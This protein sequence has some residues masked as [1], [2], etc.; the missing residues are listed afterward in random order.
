[1]QLVERMTQHPPT[2]LHCGRGNTVDEPNI[3]ALDLQREVNWGDSTYICGTCV[4]QAAA[5][6]GYISPEQYQELQDTI[7]SLQKQRH[8][9]RAQLEKKDRRL[10]AISSGR[11]ALRDERKERA[12]A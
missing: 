6:Y 4:M 2:C 10:S 8:E 7:E 9:L 11:Q 5:L 1:M 3:P 12:S